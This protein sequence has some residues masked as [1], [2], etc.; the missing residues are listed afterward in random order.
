MIPYGRH[1]ITQEDIRSVIEVLMGDWLTG[2]SAVSAFE[3]ALKDCTQ[4]RQV[5]ACSNGTTALHL[6]MIALDIRPGD[7]ALVPAITFLASANAARYMGADVVF[8]DVD[9]LTGLMTA[10]TLTQAIKNHKHMNLKVIVNVHLAGQCENLEEIASIARLYNLKI[11]EDAAHAIG[12]VYTTACG[13]RTPIGSNAFSD[14]TTFSFHPLKTIAMGEGGAVTTNNDRHA[15]KIK[16]ARS[17]GMV[18][19][20]SIWKNAVN[21]G[22]WYYE[23]HSLGYNYRVSDINCA[24]GLSQIKKLQSF[25]Q[26]RQSLS[27]LYTKLLKKCTAITPIQ[28]HAWSETAWHLYPILVDFDVIGMSRVNLMD[29]LKAHGVET[30]VHYIPLTNQ[31]YYQELYGKINLPGAESYYAKCLSLPLY[32]GLSEIDVKKITE[33]LISYA[34]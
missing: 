15:Q 16:L 26:E 17:H 34:E 11:I 22:P 6:A 20:A 19:D 2:G 30:Q 8:V 29:K 25:K 23:M 28:R 31:P 12:T 14:I 9:P 18:R 5:I 13:Q 4:A 1:N 33:L 24:L 10:E 27:N 21:T 3:T 32:S 7:V